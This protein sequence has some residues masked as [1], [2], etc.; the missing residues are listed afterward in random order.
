MKKSRCLLIYFFSVSLITGLMVIFSASTSPL[1][2]NTYG[3]DSAYF[4][5]FGTSI[6]KG[7]TLYTD[8]WDNKGP[9]FYFIQAIG[10]LH[11]THN[12]KISLIF[13]MQIFSLS[14]TIFFMWKIYIELH[15]DK[16][17]L[18]GFYGLLITGL[19]FFFSC[20]Q[21]DCG[22][23]TE[24]WSFMMISC[25]LFL[26]VKYSVNISKNVLHPRK[27]AFFHGICFALVAFIRLNNTVSICTGLLSIGIFL[28]IKKQWKN[29]FENILF[30]LLGI[31]LITIPI[32]VYFYW[33]QALNEMLYTIFTY[34]FI[35][36]SSKAHID[37][38]GIMF[39]NRYLPIMSSYFFILLYF[40]KKRTLRFV[41]ILTCSIVSANLL[42]LIFSNI[43]LHYFII[44]VPVF[45][46]VLLL[47]VEHTTNKIEIIF[48][49]AVALFFTYQCKNI[50]TE[51]LQNRNRRIFT[52]LYI[53][54]N[55]RNSAIAIDVTPEIY[56][57]T[58]IEPCSRFAAFQSIHF[59][60]VPDFESEFILDLKTKKP[61]W[62]ITHCTVESKNDYVSELINSQYQYR[63]NDAAYCFYR[64]K[65]NFL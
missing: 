33:K 27:Y 41:D 29:I 51:N 52:D 62:I 18:L 56:L 39:L 6:L 13:Q 43:Y 45:W 4:R 23:L 59:P 48:T 64:L 35:Y 28:I 54:K 36:A 1:F 65:N 47:Y 14:V 11:G 17:H 58:G 8:L 15:K 16:N 26:F 63:F 10:A 40:I 9:V 42:I 24:E 44:Y 50:V 37:L 3:I 30:G 53:P 61:L 60:V 32:F 38:T 57:N 22:N 49:I 19:V 21:Y 55:E 12:N 2:P 25:S 20:F 46:L 7:K 31:A 5:F 34:N